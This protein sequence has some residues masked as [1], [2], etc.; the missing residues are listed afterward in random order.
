MRPHDYIKQFSLQIKYHLQGTGVLVRSNEDFYLITAKHNFKKETSDKHTDVKKYSLEKNINN[1]KIISSN[2]KSIFY[3]NKILL[4]QDKLDLIIFSIRNTSSY[5]ENIDSIK[6]LDGKHYNNNYF[7]YGY[8]CDK[9]GRALSL[10]QT[11]EINKNQFRLESK[12]NIKSKYLTGFSGGGLFVEIDEI[13]YLVGILIQAEDGFSNCKAV[14]LS[15]LVDEIISISSIQCKLHFAKKNKVRDK[16][17]SNDNSNNPVFNIGSNNGAINTGSGNQYN[18]GIEKEKSSMNTAMQLFDSEKYGEAKNMF[19]EFFDENDESKIYFIISSLS[20]VT[21][22]NIKKSDINQLYNLVDSIS[23]NK[24][25]KM[26]NYLWLIIFYEYTNFHSTP[27]KLDR[28]H[29]DRRSIAFSEL[30]NNDEKKIFSSI[31][32]VTEKSTLLLISTY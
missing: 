15:S 32:T 3:A 18:Y 20:N 2:G 10:S 24:Y 1:I 26:S 19:S 28:Q 6:I 29:K 21:I 7:L 27:F 4:F 16:P 9:S 22:S 31:T 5:F 11:H 8:P 12:K 30:L 23:S 17:M 14:N 13:Y 25:K